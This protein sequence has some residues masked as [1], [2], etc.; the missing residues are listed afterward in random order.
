MSSFA[1]LAIAGVLVGSVLS[2]SALNAQ[3]N[4]TLLHKFRAG[5]FAPSG[6]LAE[7]PDGSLYGTTYCGG[8]PGAGCSGGTLF[9]LRAQPDGTWRFETLHHFRPGL[10]GGN[11]AGGLTLTRDGSLYGIATQRGRP[12]T[13][14]QLSTGT[15]FRLTP[16]GSLTVAHVFPDDS[17]GEDPIGRLLE[18]SD[19]NLYG[20]TCR[21]GRYAPLSTLFR[22]TPGGL[23]NTIHTFR[24]SES[25]ST[26]GDN[27]LDGFCPLGELTERDGFLYGTTI[28]GGRPSPILPQLPRSGTLFRVDP[29]ITPAPIT[30]LHTFRGLDGAAPTGGLTAAASGDFFGTTSS[31]GLFGQGVIFRLDAS[32]IVRNVHTFF[33][34]DGA[35]PFG[36]LFRATDGAF[37]GT[38]LRGGLGHGSVFRVGGSGFTPL[39]WF[40]GGDG[41]APLEV[42]QARDGGFYGMTTSGGPGGGGT[43][44]R[45]GA[46]NAVSTLHAFSPGLRSPL[47]GVVQATDGNF[48]GTVSG[49]SF[50]AGAVFK[51]TPGGE[52]TILHEFARVPNQPTTRQWI[53]PGALIQASDGFLYGRTTYGGDHGYGIVYRIST[54]GAFT[55][56]HSFPTF[57]GT[58]PL[59]E[60]SDGN[61]Y[62]P[63]VG[64]ADHGG[65]I[66]RIDRRGA[67]S[68]IF[69]F[70]PPIEGGGG[71]YGSIAEGPDGSLYALGTGGGP[72]N[73]SGLFKVT[74]SGAF[75]FLY[76]FESSFDPDNV[77]YRSLSGLVRGVDGGLYGSTTQ[78]LNGLPLVY[79]FDSATNTIGAVARV[80]TDRPLAVGRDG[81]I[82]G[83]T[84]Y[85]EGPL[86]RLFRLEQGN[87]EFLYDMVE[88]DGLNPST[89]IQGVDGVLYGTVS[90]G[91]WRYSQGTW[92]D[93]TFAGGVFRIT[94]PPAPPAASSKIRPGS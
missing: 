93:D 27:P 71:V 31:G 7:T 64:D 19:G 75:T 65:A 63:I 17:I 90:E 68:R 23:F 57:A 42:M 78:H 54:S 8:E 1:R 10:H 55:E 85:A 12:I 72:F 36:R 53:A 5:A 44:Y 38:T 29:T 66:F 37:Y 62:G 26:Y 88:E 2:S 41:S 15:I 61:L 28:A 74:T 47:G 83:W 4:Y 94:V 9:V 91:P 13:S 82:Y 86:F 32:G 3:S 34:L 40:N 45:M 52:I 89:V 50:G 58:E 76:A 59:I 35:Q 49:S 92:P 84:G 39:H 46:D 43:I 20:A 48:Y 18:G 11:P 67:F 79:R 30:V 14:Q 81:A 21:Y 51:M 77:G 70:P 33:G 69:S 6:R 80:Y 73:A 25:G 60:A 22:L 24:M 16:S 87:M 56:L